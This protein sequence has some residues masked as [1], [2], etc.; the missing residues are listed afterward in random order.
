[1]LWFCKEKKYLIISL[2]IVLLDGIIIYFIPSF[3]NK[4][5]YLY[6]MLTITLIPFIVKDKKRIWLVILLGFIYDLLYTNIFLY[7]TIIFLLLGILNNKI[8]NYFNS[9]MFPYIL[10]TILNIIMY[11]SITFLLVII[12]NYQDIT[13]NDL[14]YK[15]KHSLLLNI[16][17]V[18]I[19]FFLFNKKLYKHK[20]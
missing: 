14:L 5:N 7:N 19:Y 1:M 13:I 17:S 11:D 9:S 16:M 15:I 4:I 8:I 18:F 6:P 10:L 3:F 2:L 20:M 12:T